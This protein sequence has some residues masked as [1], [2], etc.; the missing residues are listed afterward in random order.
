[1]LD[2]LALN[3]CG[4]LSEQLRFRLVRISR[5]ADGDDCCR[6]RDEDPLLTSL[7]FNGELEQLSISMAFSDADGS[8][9]S[10]MDDRSVPSSL[11]SSAGS[12]ALATFC[13]N[14]D[15]EAPSSSIEDDGELECLSKL[16]STGSV[17]G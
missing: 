10:L 3:G 5:Q 15:D 12:L 11:S 7:L 13:D 9:A 2:T 14:D 17:D 1:M 6:S 4:N 8:D 16:S